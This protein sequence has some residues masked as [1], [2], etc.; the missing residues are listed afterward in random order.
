MFE[1]GSPVW[2]PDGSRFAISA[3]RNGDWEECRVY[4]VDVR[5]GDMIPITPDAEL[6]C[7]SPEDWSRDGRWILMSVYVHDG[8]TDLYKVRPDGSGL[9]NLTCFWSEGQY[10][11]NARWTRDGR[12]I[13]FEAH[14]FRKSG[15]F[16][17]SAEGTNRQALFAIPSARRRQ[18]YLG[19]VAVSPDRKRIAYIVHDGR[20]ETH[21]PDEVFVID[22]DRGN[23]RRVTFNSKDETALAWAPDSRHL[24]TIVGNMYDRY[25]E[26]FIKTIDVGSGRSSE[27]RIP[28]PGQ[29]DGRTLVW[30]PSGRYVAFMVERD[31]TSAVFVGSMSGSSVRRVTPFDEMIRLR[32]WR[33]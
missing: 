28:A 7:P 30:S 15:I 19:D 23:N 8:P 13:L 26:S 12:S 27:I 32:D 4:V 5:T 31:S 29:I 9:D 20:K 6:A 21:R 22:V 16:V 11:Y 10:A 1:F 33:R 3:N 18:K 17:M 25:A 14:G 2:S 24:A